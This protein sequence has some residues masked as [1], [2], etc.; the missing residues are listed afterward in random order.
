MPPNFDGIAPWYGLL[1]RLAFGGALQRCRRGLLDRVAGAGRVLIAG[2]GDGRFLEA[3]LR[4][5]PAARIT[6]VDSSPRMLALARS[7]VDESACVQFVL[8]DV[9]DESIPLPE[10]D[11]VVTC[12]FLDCFEGDDQ[13]RVI[14]RLRRGLQPGGLWL[15]ADFELPARQP[16]KSVA[17]YLIG[18]LYGFF[19]L[20][21]GLN[22]RRLW[23]PE[24]HFRSCGL[25]PVVSHAS[26][27]GLLRTVLYRVSR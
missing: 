6:V 15:W 14:S 9:M 10:V 17:R 11:L 12:F 7:R 2:E 4:A 25:E 27:G 20:A 24:A 16:L 19:R 22:T 8:G 21:T 13:G 5:N 26:L 18:G 23:P 1:E 3:L